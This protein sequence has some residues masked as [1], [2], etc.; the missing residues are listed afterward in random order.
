LKSLERGEHG[1]YGGNRDDMSS[2]IRSARKAKDP[3]GFD[4]EVVVQTD[5]S[6]RSRSRTRDRGSAYAQEQAGVSSFEEWQRFAV[7]TERFI[8]VRCSLSCLGGEEEAVHDG[9]EVCA[10]TGAHASE[11]TAASD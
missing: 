4:P 10:W 9:V 8:A 2:T 7:L 3:V 11:I 5:R 6:V 1:E